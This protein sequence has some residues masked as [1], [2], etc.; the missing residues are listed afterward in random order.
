MTCFTVAGLVENSHINMSIFF[1]WLTVYTE[2][3]PMY[4]KSV[5]LVRLLINYR[6]EINPVVFQISLSTN[7]NGQT[8]ALRKENKHAPLHLTWNIHLY[9]YMLSY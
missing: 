6:K 9:S 4:I 2:E 8:N 1:G 3:I 7:V 5:K